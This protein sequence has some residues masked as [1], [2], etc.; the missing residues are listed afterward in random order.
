MKDYE[1]TKDGKIISLKNNKRYEI[2]GYID[3]YGYRRVL[4][5]VNGKRIKFFVHR[6]VAQTYI[7]NPNNLPQVNH[8]DGNKLNNNVENLEWCTPKENIQHA[9]KKG[10]R[11]KKGKLNISDIKEI[12]LLFGNKSMKEIAELYNVSLS[13]IKH[14]HAGHTWKDI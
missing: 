8:I 1:I 13:C 2:K 3:K 6:L 10:L 5:H 9:I 11:V 14:L 12:R 7:P 4:L